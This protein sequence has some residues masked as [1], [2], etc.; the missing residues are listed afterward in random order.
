MG[1]MFITKKFKSIKKDVINSNKILMASEEISDKKINDLK[2]FEKK[3]EIKKDNEVISETEKEETSTIKNKK[4]SK[5]NRKKDM[6]TEE[7]IAEIETQ[8]ENIVNN[9]KKIKKD[10]GLIERAESSKIILT[11]DNR[12]VLND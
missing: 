5:K 2:A 4:N 11:E 12:Q 10:R 1:K 3:D 9:V 8:T 6:I 7:Q